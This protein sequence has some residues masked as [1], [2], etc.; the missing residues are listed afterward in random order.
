MSALV[1][2]LAALASSIAAQSAV[3]PVTPP[4][5]RAQLEAD[6]NLAQKVIDDPTSASGD[7]ETAGQFEQLA[8]AALA[9]EPLATQRATLT[10][11]GRTAAAV[12]RANLDAATHLARLASPRKAFP[13]W[14]VI[15][16][17]AAADLLGYFKAAQAQS[18][19]PWEYLAAIEFV[20]S[21]FGRVH[22][23]S[24]AGAQGPMQFL[25]ASWARYGRGDVNNPRDAIFAAARYLVANGAP[26][27]MANAL[28]HYNPSG[29]YVSAITDYALR[30]RA[31]PRAYYGYYWWQVLY[32]RRGR[33]FVLPV[34]YPRLRPVPVAVPGAHTRSPPA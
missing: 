7:I 31:D 4:S 18:G 12:L 20:E 5:N 3:L 6:L 25:P 1:A 26:D 23:L 21:R 29:D 22:G 33:T 9:R 34:G 30:M 17:P 13:P 27:A 8:T 2:I 15:A 24:T 11:L 10:G 16:P 14:R 32:A 28:Y 19:V